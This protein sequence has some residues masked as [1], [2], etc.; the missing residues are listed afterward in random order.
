M[1][2]EV[3]EGITVRPLR[4]GETAVVQAVFDRLGPRSRSLR[5][6]GAK[7]V[8]QASEL[9]HLARVDAD[10]HVLV[11]YLRGEP[12][13]IARLVREGDEA[14]VA[15]A[16]VDDLQGNGIGTVLVDRLGAD[17]RAAGIRRFRA[18][19]QPD[20]KPSLALAARLKAA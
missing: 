11:A 20:N 3:I 6:H 15:F 10:H 5:F 4:N 14:E 17:A 19:V 1:N 9:Q 13:G 7:N 12:V 8:L 18:D 16:V 2:A